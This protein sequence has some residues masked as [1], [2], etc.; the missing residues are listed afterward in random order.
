[1]G[2]SPV[3]GGGRTKGD[4]RKEAIWEE[5]VQMLI[6]EY[7]SKGI[8]YR[9]KIMLHLVRV[10]YNSR[11]ATKSEQENINMRFHQ[12]SIGVLSVWVYIFK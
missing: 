1:M 11:I 10:S 5:G 4:S 8:C 2:G 6:V 7:T 3:G 9:Y 12:M